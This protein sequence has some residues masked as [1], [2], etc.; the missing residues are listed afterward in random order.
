MVMLDMWVMVMQLQ[1]H[2]SLQ[3]VREYALQTAKQHAAVHTDPLAS[4]DRWKGCAV[5]TPAL[6]T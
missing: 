3:N 4:V 2:A 1:A 6:P 5:V